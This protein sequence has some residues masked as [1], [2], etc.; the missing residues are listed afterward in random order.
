MHVI[1]VSILPKF[2]E[3]PWE[4]LNI[5]KDMKH[6]QANYYIVSAG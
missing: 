6:L 2:L 4:L 5:I 3:E 1:L